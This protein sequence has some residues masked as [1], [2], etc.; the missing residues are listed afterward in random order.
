MRNRAGSLQIRLTLQAP[1]ARPGLADIAESPKLRMF[2]PMETISSMAAQLNG[3]HR[4]Q[5]KSGEEV[6]AAAA[7]MEE[8]ARKQEQHL[9]AIGSALATL[10][11]GLARLNGGS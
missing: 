9:R 7:R 1:Y 2:P 6:L 11:D 5:S 8:V 10:R 3:A 4:T